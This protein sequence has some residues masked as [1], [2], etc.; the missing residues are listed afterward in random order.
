MYSLIVEQMQFCDNE[1]R[2]HAPIS[3]VLISLCS[4]YYKCVAPIDEQ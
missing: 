3:C 4:D 2:I 1:D